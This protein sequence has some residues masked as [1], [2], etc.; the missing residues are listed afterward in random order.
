M[1]TIIIL[2]SWTQLVG[3]F[4]KSAY[5]HFHLIHICSSKRDSFHCTFK[6]D[7]CIHD[8]WEKGYSCQISLM[9]LNMLFLFSLK[10]KYIYHALR[11]YKP[12]I[13]KGPYKCLLFKNALINEFQT[14]FQ[15]YFNI[16]ESSDQENKPKLSEKIHYKTNYQ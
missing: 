16:F 6:N 3:M 9:L 15:M 2:D 4:I 10:I 12:L 14:Y 11:S 5:F 7:K 13:G 8:I 1:Q